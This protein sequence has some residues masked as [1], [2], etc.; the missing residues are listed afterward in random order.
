MM[1]AKNG[2]S[3]KRVLFEIF[4]VP[5]QIMEQTGI[6]S[7][8]SIMFAPIMLPIDRE[9]CFLAMAVTVVTSSGREVPIATA[10][11]L[12]ILRSTMKILSAIRVPL[13]TKRFEPMTI[14]AVPTTK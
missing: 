3:I 5:P 12:I 6:I 10:V 9:L 2:R 14:P 4:K 11:R 8:R 7:V 1:R 13:S